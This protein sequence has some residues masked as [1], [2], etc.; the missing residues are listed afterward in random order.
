MLVG[1]LNNDKCKAAPLHATEAQRKGRVINLCVNDFN[2]RRCWQSV[3]HPG[4]FIS[5]KE[6]Q[7]SFYRRLVGPQGWSGWL[8]IFYPLLHL[9][10]N[11]PSP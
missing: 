5:R 1:Y 9:N 4:H 8:Q 7:Y 10:T 2:T 3:S 11:P 6:T